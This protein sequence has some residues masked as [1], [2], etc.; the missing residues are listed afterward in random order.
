MSNSMIVP[1]EKVKTWDKNDS[2]RIVKREDFQ[3]L[4]N[5]IAK[6]GV[7]KPLICYEDNGGYITLG[8]NSRLRV[9]RDLGHKEVWV[10]V[11]NPKSEAEKLEI[12][13]SDND[14]VAIYDQS[15]LAELVWNEKDNISLDDFKIDL[16]NPISLKELLGEISSLA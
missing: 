1:I 14:R 2:L 15:A 12:N 4:K 11:V 8:G 9:C 16:G 13:L 3:R 6:Y 7:Y 5:Q 10:S